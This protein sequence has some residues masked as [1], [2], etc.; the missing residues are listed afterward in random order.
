MLWVVIA[1]LV[2]GAIGLV[3]YLCEKIKNYSLKGVL[4]KAIVSMLFVSVAIVSALYK[5]GHIFNSFIIIGLILGLSGDIWLDLK[6][7]YPKDDRLYTFAGFTVFGVGHI[8]FIIGM[9]TEFFD[10]YNVLHIILPF[11]GAL[12][13]A[14]ANLFLEKPM[15]LNFGE[16]KWVVFAYSFLLFSTPFTALSLLIATGWNNTTLIMMFIGGILFAISDLVLSNTYFGENHEKPIDFLL[17]YL[18]YYSAQFVIA[19]SI[20]FI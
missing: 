7:V 14:F 20:F 11:V 4:I 2:L 16:L 1:L 5:H 17:N 9:F 6:Y 10:G 12:L 18:A 19:F 13:A 15:K 8:M 3:F